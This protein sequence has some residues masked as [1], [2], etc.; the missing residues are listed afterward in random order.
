[1]ISLRRA[2]DARSAKISRV[3]SRHPPTVEKLASGHQRSQITVNGHSV[4]NAVARI[5]G[6]APGLMPPSGETVHEFGMRASL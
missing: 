2:P 5:R 1:M 4:L 6:T 3:R